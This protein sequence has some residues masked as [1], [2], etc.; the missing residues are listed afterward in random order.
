MKCNLEEVDYLNV[1]LNLIDGTYHP[2]HKTNEEI[3]YIHVE[4]DHPPQIMK[5][6]PRLIEK[7]LSRLSS[8]KEIF[9]NSKDYYEQRLRQFRY[10]EELNYTKRKQRTKSKISEAQHALVQPTS[11]QICEN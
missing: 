9:E 3:T 2:F 11:L 8:T 4:S 7:K 5:K 10:N 1:T 6:I